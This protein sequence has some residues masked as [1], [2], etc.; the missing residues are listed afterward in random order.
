MA[1]MANMKKA[2]I[3]ELKNN[4]SLYLRY[5]RRGGSVLVFDRDVAVARIVPVS[6]ARSHTGGDGARLEHLEREGL[7]RRGTGGLPGWLSRPRPRLQRSLLEEF[8][9][10]RRS[11]W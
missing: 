1:N 10:E 6:T 3:A 4:L 2:K 11:G 5:V 9:A 7:I 8:L